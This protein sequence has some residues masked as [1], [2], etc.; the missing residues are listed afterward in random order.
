MD[1][2]VVD[3]YFALIWKSFTNSIADVGF[4]VHRHGSQVEQFQVSIFKTSCNL[5][6]CGNNLKKISHVLQF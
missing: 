6:G 5:N 2:E 3:T 4:P 1:S